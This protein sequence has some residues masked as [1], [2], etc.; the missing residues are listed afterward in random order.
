VGLIHFIVIF[1]FFGF[2]FFFFLRTVRPISA[3]FAVLC[4]LLS[5]VVKLR[6]YFGEIT[7]RLICS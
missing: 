2:V 1:L 7:V 5:S 3:M 6:R 4:F